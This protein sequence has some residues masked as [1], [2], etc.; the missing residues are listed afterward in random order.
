MPSLVT[1]VC[2]EGDFMGYPV[3]K[4]FETGEIVTKRG[5]DRR[6]GYCMREFF[7]VRAIWPFWFTRAKLMS[8]LSA[9]MLQLGFVELLDG[10]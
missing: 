5:Q 7:G 8:R 1:C 10:A 9:A 6:K 4:M 3:C 2:L